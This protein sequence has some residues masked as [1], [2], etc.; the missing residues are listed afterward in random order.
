M[1]SERSFRDFDWWLLAVSL[2][3]CAIGVLQIYSATLDTKW[4]D[5]WWKQ[6]IW[7]AV[8][9]LCMWLVMQVDYHTLLGQV[10]VLY[11]VSIGLLVLTLA[12]GYVMGSRR[13]IGYGWAK[14]QISEF[15]KVVL[16][17]M[18][19]RYLSE[20]RTPHLEL[21]NLARLVAL[22]GVP[23]VIVM[24]QPDL[25]TAL[26]YTPILGIGVFLAGLRWQHLLTIVGLAVVLLP[27]SWF[28]LRDYQKSRIMTFID[29][30]HDA[31]GA[32]Y[33]VIQSKIAIGSGG[34][35]GQGATKGLQTQLRFLP[36]PHTD[37]IFSTF[38]E[39][40]GF[41]GVFFLMLLQIVQNAQT[42]PDREG[43]YICMGVAALLLFHILVNIG[44]V[45][46]RM[47]V[48]GIPLPLVSSGGSNL[49]TVFILIG[50]VNNVRLRRFGN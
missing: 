41:V 34:L 2:V 22:V 19:A 49:V 3:L 45:V 23:M 39:E 35:W 7:L 46:G 37:F 30:Q 15:F 4:R 44:M 33:Q 20:L 27:A 11:S 24:M 28:V 31:K 43:L 25:G 17:L 50:L 18:V 29:P 6:L 47:P 10:P 21:R 16:V 32:G 40:H 38:A 36:V 42:A 8:S 14:F 5:T 12:T 26:T 1:S 9:L 13:W 48:T